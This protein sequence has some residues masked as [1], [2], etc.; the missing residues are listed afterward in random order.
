MTLNKILHSPVAAGILLILTSLAAIIVCNTDGERFYTSFIHAS[1]S[2][3]S[4][5]KLVNDVLMSL[6]FLLVG[7]EIKREFLTGQLAQW[8]QRILPG[9]AAIGGMI[10]PAAIYLLINRHHPQTFS[11]WAIPSATDIAF[12]LGILS[13]LGNK[14]PTSLKVFLAALAIIDD[15][16]AVVIIA[17][18]Y[19]AQIDVVMLGGAMLTVIGLILLNRRGVIALPIYIFL[20]L[21]LWYFIERSGIHATVAGVLLALCIPHS[22]QKLGQPSPL[23]KLEHR[24]APWV[25]FLIIPIFGFVNAGVSFIHTTSDQLISALPLGI[26]LGLFVGKQLGISLTAFILIIFGWAQ[27]PKGATYC[28]FYG[29]ATLCGIGF[30]MSLFI[31]SLAFASHPVLLDEVKI[32][33]LGGSFLSAI[34]GVILLLFAGRH[35]S[36]Q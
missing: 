35:Q 23:L 22:G 10:V 24:L 2:G 21:L 8:S 6:F 9:T 18:F 34:F 31:G 36:S 12:S 3:M 20:G 32:G 1:V 17:L 5:E 7:L 16:G 27:L 15:L 19:T 25:S 4:I 33:V 11:G 30:T 13:L 14:V 26:M 28:Q 29:V